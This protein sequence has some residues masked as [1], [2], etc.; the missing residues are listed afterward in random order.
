MEDQV[1][2]SLILLLSCPIFDNVLVSNSVKKGISI[3]ILIS[4]NAAIDKNIW[5]NI[6]EDVY[7]V[8]LPLPENFFQPTSIFWL[9]I[10][11]ERFNPFCCQQA[12]IAVDETHLIWG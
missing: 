6:G 4:K 9:N 5:K 2:D 12:A 8:V 3:I 11:R 1:D 10:I 7:L